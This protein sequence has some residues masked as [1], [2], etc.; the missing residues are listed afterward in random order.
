MGFNICLFRVKDGIAH[1]LPSEDWWATQHA[2][3][4]GKWDSGRY[5]WDH[6]IK[7]SDGTDRREW[8]QVAPDEYGDNGTESMWRPSDAKIAEVKAA[9]PSNPRAQLLVAT[10]ES[11]PSI[12][13]AWL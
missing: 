6:E 7:L 11:D 8:I 12:M 3:P 9:L 10:L 5:G 4:T 2:S 1:E 13:V